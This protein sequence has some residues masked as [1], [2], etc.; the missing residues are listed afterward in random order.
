MSNEFFHSNFFFYDDLCVAIY[1]KCLELD[2]GRLSIVVV[3]G[4]VHLV[5]NCCRR[6]R[7]RSRRGRTTNQKDKMNKIVLANNNKKICQK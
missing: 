5:E 4:L 6:R 3:V 2:S 1:N 7:R